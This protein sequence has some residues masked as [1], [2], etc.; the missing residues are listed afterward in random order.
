M[1]KDSEQGRTA[2]LSVHND[3]VRA[4]DQNKVSLLLLLDLSAAFDT[5]DHSILLSVLC[6]RFNVSGT[7]FQWF[8]SYLSDRSQSFFYDGQQTSSFEVDCSVPQGSVLGPVEF[9][10][11]TE[12]IT[13][14]IDKHH[15]QSHFYAD[16][17]QIYDSCRPNDISDVRTRLS[18]C[19]TEISSWCASRR[20]QLNAEKTEAIWFGSRANLRRLR[21]QER[22]VHVGPASV[23]PVS[24]VRNL[25][26]LLDDEL[27]LKQHVNRTAATCFLYLRRLRQIRRRIGQDL[28]VRLILAL[29]TARLDYCNSVLAGLP[30]LTLEPLQRAQNAAARLVFKL[31][32][33]DH[34]APCLLQLHWLPICW[35]VKFKLCTI[36]HTV[37]NGLGPEYLAQLVQPVNQRPTRTG[38]RSANSSDYGLPRLR[39]K[40]GERA[41]SHAGPA[42]WNSLPADIRAESNARRFKRLLKTYFFTRAFNVS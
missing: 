15:V 29:I 13:D 35:R 39:T 1:L 33:Q 36:M 8:K 34:I 38:L 18:N 19:A 6:R 40:F 27:C 14:V 31:R 3:L 42:I 7:S 24:I 41:F 26:V 37:H 22:N 23:S 30:R 17:T 12:D 16:D 32:S 25:G 10:A 28:T 9:V 5:V 21:D 11:Y 20:L 2:V 4:I